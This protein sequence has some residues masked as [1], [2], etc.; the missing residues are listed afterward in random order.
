MTEIGRTRGL[1]NTEGMARHAPGSAGWLLYDG[2]CPIC[3]RGVRRI[4]GVVRKRGFGVMPLQRRWV[5]ERLAA[6]GETIPDEMLLL[7]PDD[8]L[9]VGVDAFLYVGRR[10]WWAA[11][12]AWLMGLPGFRWLARRAYAWVARNRYAIS[13]ACTK[14]TCGVSG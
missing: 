7:L 1:A 14:E 12:A 8:R 9:L 6:R 4:A 11:P 2:R 10:I 5:A 3:R 13:H